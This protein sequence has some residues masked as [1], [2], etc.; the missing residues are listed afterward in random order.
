MKNKTLKFSV[1][2]SVLLIAGILSLNT[3]RQATLSSDLISD[4][5]EEY[6][7]EFREGSFAFYNLEHEFNKTQN[8]QTGRIPIGI[9]ARQQAFAR[10]L[11][12]NASKD[13]SWTWR[14]PDN[15]GGRMLCVAV[16]SQDENH[17]LAGSA[18]GGMWQSL[19]AGQT[20]AK[21]T[22]PDAEQSATCIVQDPR[23]GKHNTWYYGTGEM[24]STTSRNISTNVRTIGI[25][26]GICKST[27]N[28]QTWQPLPSTQGGSPSFLNEVFQGVWKI[29]VDPASTDKDIVLAACYG[30]I[31]RSE[32]GGET[33]QM[34]LGDLENKSFGTDIVVTNDGVFYALLGGYGYGLE[35]PMKKG[36]WRSTDG[37][38]W[39]N[40]T[41]EGF[42]DD[43]RASR[44]AL[45][46]SNKNI[47][48]VFTESQSPVLH[49]FNGY[50]NTIN[51]FWKM[52]WDEENDSAVWEDRTTGTPGGG[53]GDMN[54]FPYSFVCYGGYCVT[55]AVKPDNENVVLLGGMNLFRSE[56]GFAD[57]SQ[58]VFMGGYPYDMD[59]LHAIHPDLHGLTFSHSNPDKMMAAC[60]GGIY[61]TNNCLADSASMYWNR[62][63]TN[64]TT[65]QF[66]S[67][68]IDHGSTG[69]DWVLGGLQD[70]NWYYTVTDDPTELWFSIDICYDGFATAVAPNWQYCV[71]SAYSGNI[72][73]SQFD[74][75]MHTKN[76]YSQLPDTL[77]S[78]YD[79]VMGSN[80][81]FP[82]YQNFALDPNNAETFYL[83]T[84]TS[85]WRKDNLKASALDS[86]LRNVGWS[87]LSNVDV[88]D[89]SEI[90]Y[91][92]VSKYP[93]N[94]LF[95]GTSLGRVYRLDEAN[96]GNPIPVDISGDN[97][98]PNA[99]VACVD[100]D[101]NNA[102]SLM[103]VFSNYEVQSIFSSADGGSTWT[104]QGGNLEQNPDG[105]GDGP[106]VRFVKSLNYQGKKVWF[107][108]TSV[109]LF[110]TAQLA[111]DATVWSREGAQTI[112]SVIVDMID[113]RQSDGFV[114]I[115][116][117]GNGVYSAYY[118]PING[119]GTTVKPVS[120]NIG[121]PFPN[122]ATESVF[123]EI[124][125]E[126]PQMLKVKLYDLNGKEL[127]LNKDFALTTGSDVF[128]LPLGRPDPGIYL[129][130]F[131][132]QTDEVT[133]RILIK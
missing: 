97:F 10:K 62:L 125:S 42:P 81:L 16:D 24:L 115:A 1:A 78:F 100:V 64:L 26:N 129:M 15:I 99:F 112:G 43:N 107:A 33:W 39:Q 116:T 88:G 37:I 22:A 65:S 70:N 7:E 38:D 110:S 89:A 120:L 84:V 51:T 47:M 53:S 121:E 59:S 3:K 50:T 118:N 72:W 32:D 111:G 28:G 85:I 104:A 92:T 2:V 58:T 49:P 82:F 77:L 54:D 11:P 83:P 106:S 74:E 23:P 133:R 124:T 73:T 131:S 109:G 68:A 8:P 21:V 90:S 130:R 91:I 5:E 27:D 4:K 76:I 40:I 80:S 29:V 44:L 108:G 94:R 63:N 9:K 31:M 56:N 69:D 61:V 71:I 86:S 52:T 19:D 128:E 14:G 57:S 46:Q 41:P 6:M 122:P 34:V 117:H 96:T 79:P 126:I 123:V 132:T 25:G 18:S 98:P 66:Y 12:V 127:P 102:D 87:H 93:A 119:I 60:D 13:Q 105:S 114:A 45:A 20:W 35:P 113:A 48:Y 67:V 103:V 101:E 55:L 30:A 75:T 17:L 36:V 95:Y